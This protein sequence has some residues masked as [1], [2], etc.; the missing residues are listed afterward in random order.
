MQNSMLIVF[1]KILL[2][3]LF[4]FSFI[5]TIDTIIQKCRKDTV[6]LFG[7]FLNYVYLCQKITK[8]NH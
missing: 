2:M 1:C 7:I 6:F 4:V 3:W 8:I 5:N